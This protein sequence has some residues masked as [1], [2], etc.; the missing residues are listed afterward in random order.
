MKAQSKKGAKFKKTG[1]LKKKKFDNGHKERQ[2]VKSQKMTKNDNVG[3]KLK[4]PAEQPPKSQEKW[5][6]ERK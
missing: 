6:R 4:K 3:K 1:G 2:G 5:R